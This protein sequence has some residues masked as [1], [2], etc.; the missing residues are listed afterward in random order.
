MISEEQQTY[1]LA[2]CKKGN[3]QAQ[4]K[5]YR[6]FYRALMNICLRYTKND[7]DAMEALNTGFYKVFKN[8]ERY[9]PAQAS[10]YTWIR[11]IVIN[12]CLDLT[13]TKE[14]NMV[15][16]ELTEAIDASVDPEVISKLSAARLLEIIRKLPAATQTV[17]NLF[18]ME[19]Y[20][21]REIAGL[22]NISEGTSKWHV[23]D[24]RK[25][26]QT[27]INDDNH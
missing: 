7:M 1:L 23:S 4:E 19:G 24:A 10:L 25:K 15:S 6:S 5:L 2:G 11:T 22:L 27:I 3:R 17:F 20:S 18:I 8:I 9:D 12:S 21:H 13:G 16:Q 26:L 14:K